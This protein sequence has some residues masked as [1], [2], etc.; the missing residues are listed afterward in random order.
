MKQLWI[1]IG[2][3]CV[4]FCASAQTVSSTLDSLLM[5]TKYVYLTEDKDFVQMFNQMED[6]HGDMIVQQSLQ[7]KLYTIHS[8]RVLKLVNVAKNSLDTV[9]NKRAFKKNILQELET[10]R[11]DAETDMT[12]EDYDEFKFVIKM[13]RFIVRMM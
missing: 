3:L 5:D 1:I 11:L 10:V 9:S 6:G 8:I 7:D 13:M 2:L 12:S 4:N